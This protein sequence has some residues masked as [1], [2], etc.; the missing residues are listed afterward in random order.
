MSEEE[1]GQ[2][3]RF[4][5]FRG[6][7][8]SRSDGCYVRYSD[9]E[10]LQAELAEARRCAEISGD[11]FDDLLNEATTLALRVKALTDALEFIPQSGSVLGHA[12][13]TERRV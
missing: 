2:V 1:T 8:E 10:R 4:G 11:K 3:E 13:E 9:Y 6:G 5:E 7:L 12:A